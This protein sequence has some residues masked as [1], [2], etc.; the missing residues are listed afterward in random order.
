MAR[1]LNSQSNHAPSE[2]LSSRYATWLDDNF[3]Q[4]I[5]WALWFLFMGV[6]IAAPVFH[7]VENRGNLKTPVD[8]RGANATFFT[9][10]L[11]W[12]D[13]LMTMSFLLATILLISCFALWQGR[14]KQHNPR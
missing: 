11:L 13:I 2:G 6:W 3:Q 7:C 9:V 12:A 1:V 14:R 8:I 10:S 4:I 5:R